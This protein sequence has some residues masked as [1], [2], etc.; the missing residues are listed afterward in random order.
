VKENKLTNLLKFFY[1]GVLQADPG[2]IREHDHIFHLYCHE[3]Q[4]VFHDRLVDSHDKTYFNTMLS[5]MASK[6]FSKVLGFEI[7]TT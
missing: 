5:E 4:R 3:C 6:H 7:T 2:L 1:P